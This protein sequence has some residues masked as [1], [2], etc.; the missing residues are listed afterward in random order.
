MR[1]HWTFARWSERHDSSNTSVE[2]ASAAVVFP[3]ISTRRLSPG[4]IIDC[5]TERPQLAAAEYAEHSATRPGHHQPIKVADNQPE[6]LR[7][8]SFAYSIDRIGAMGFR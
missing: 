4:W 1:I 6:A 3:R 7:I 5:H 2:A 8:S